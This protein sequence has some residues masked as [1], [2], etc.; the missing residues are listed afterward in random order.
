MP[1]TP[2]PKSI[3]AGRVLGGRYTL[4]TRIA[5]GGMGEVWRVRDQRTGMLVAAKVL[6]PELRG[7]AISLSRLRLEASNTLRAHHPNIATVLDSGEDD[8]QGWIIMELIDGNPLTDYVGDG[9]RLTSEQLIPIL[10]QTAFA[11]DSSAQ[12]GVVHRDIKPANIIVRPDGIAKLTDFGISFAEGQANLT[13]VGMVMGTAQYLAPE[14]AVGNEATPLGDLY[15]LGVIA[16][17]ALAG[18]RPFTGPSPVEI[19]M[20]HVKEDLPPL[21]DDV[22]PQMQQVVY[23]LLEKDP[24]DRPQSGAGLIRL[25]TN[26]AR[27]LGTTTAPK[28]L[29]EV[30]PKTVLQPASIPKR[31][32]QKTEKEAVPPM[33]MAQGEQ[34]VS[35]D[36][37]LWRPLGERQTSEPP[38]PSK[39][40]EKEDSS[41]SGNVGMWL[42]GALVILTVILIFVAMIRDRSTAAAAFDFSPIQV[43]S[44]TEV[45]SW[46]IPIPDC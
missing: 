1:A 45:M 35:G 6:R 43:V 46:L 18:H 29:A 31:A 7:E 14:Q 38:K 36:A 19:A 23:K 28:P 10:I 37:P 22:P 3:R 13:A 39:R 11:L 32:P 42:V 4:V 25:L 16:Y 2:N 15:S 41:L 17:E 40:P 20:A 44:S 12:A 34:Q 26:A 30:V 9:K 21:P 27:E 8:G 24:A 33:T 5:T